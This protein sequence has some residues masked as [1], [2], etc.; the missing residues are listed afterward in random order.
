MTRVQI[1]DGAIILN[2]NAQLTKSLKEDHEID[3]TKGS[4]IKFIGRIYE[5]LGFYDEAINYY[6]KAIEIFIYNKKGIILYQY[7]TKKKPDRNIELI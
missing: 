6:K 2:S 5:L 3:S 1:P 4:P 7:E